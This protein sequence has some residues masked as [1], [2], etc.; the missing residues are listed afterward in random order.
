MDATLTRAAE[1]RRGIRVTEFEQRQLRAIRE[2]IDRD[3][4]ARNAMCRGPRTC[5]CQVERL[6]FRGLSP[7][8]GPLDLIK[9]NLIVQRS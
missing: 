4:A 1:R 5:T 2:E 8:H 7:R 6:R 9:V 3:C